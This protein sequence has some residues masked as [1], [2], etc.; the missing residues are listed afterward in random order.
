[1]HRLILFIAITLL[2]ACM[3][4]ATENLDLQYAEY[5]GSASCQSCHDQIH[6]RWTQ[7]LMANVLQDP[8]EQPDAILG[9]FTQEDPLLTFT[10]DDVVFT[11]GSKWKQRYYTQRGD[12]YFILPAQWDVQ[13]RQWRR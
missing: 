3:T 7:T 5:A 10:P 8:R 4:R 6:D 13:N 2:G 12:D 11:Y 9:D 1:M